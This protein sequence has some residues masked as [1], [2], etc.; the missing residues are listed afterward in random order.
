MDIILNATSSVDP[1]ARFV[2]GTLWQHGGHVIIAESFHDRCLYFRY[3][4]IVGGGKMNEDRWSRLEPVPAAEGE[5]LRYA[6][7]SG[8]C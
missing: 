1:T 5:A 7:I 3:R 2:R 6:P 4:D 8:N